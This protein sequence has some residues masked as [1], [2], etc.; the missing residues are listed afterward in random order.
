MVGVLGAITQGNGRRASVVAITGV[1]GLVCWWLVWR[2]STRQLWR[3]LQLTI[4]THQNGSVFLIRVAHVSDAAR[5]S[6]T[7]GGAH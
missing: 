7:I 6:C 2:M 1:S 4:L 5:G 3:W